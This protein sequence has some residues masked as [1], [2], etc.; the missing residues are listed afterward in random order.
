MSVDKPSDALRARQD[1]WQSEIRGPFVAAN[2]ER[3]DPFHTQALKWPVQ[4]LYTPLDLEAAG[5]D[6]QK[7]LGF[8]GEYPIR[9]APTRMAIARSSGR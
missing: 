2:P 9:A 4:A 1:L 8:P 3:L 6:Y 5:F 7:D